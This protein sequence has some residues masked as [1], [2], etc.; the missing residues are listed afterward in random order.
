MDLERPLTRPHQ[1]PDPMVFDLLVN[2][3]ATGIAGILVKTGKRLL[4]RRTKKRAPMAT[5]LEEAR[6]SLATLTALVSELHTL[7]AHAE[8]I[9]PPQSK[10]ELGGVLMLSPDE[11][12][13]Y[14]GLRDALIDKLKRVDDLAMAHEGQLAGF[15]VESRTRRRLPKEFRHLIATAEKRLTSARTATLSGIA[16]LDVKAAAVAMQAM[17]EILQRETA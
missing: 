6:T 12:G 8:T 7:I 13:R 16:L 1:D 9:V 4:A 10:R 3:A 15:E 11:I 2:L 14:L 17:L 5:P